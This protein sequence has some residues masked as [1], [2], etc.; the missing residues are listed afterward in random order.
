MSIDNSPLVPGDKYVAG[1]DYEADVQILGREMVDAVHST[2]ATTN[3]A[4]VLTS[5]GGPS[6]PFQLE[7]AGASSR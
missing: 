2:K 1:E 4:Y 3:G 6:T 7:R 5:T